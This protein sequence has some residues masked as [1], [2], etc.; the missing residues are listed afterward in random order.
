MTAS[1]GAARATESTGALTGFGLVVMGG[2]VEGAALGLLQAETL[3]DLLGRRRDWVLLTVLLAGLGWAAGSAL[4]TL[5]SG[6]SGPAPALAPILL[7]AAGLGLLMGS[8]LG[9]AQATV[10]RGRVRHPWR[11]VVANGCAWALA[12][13]VVFAGATTAGASWSWLAVA[14]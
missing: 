11:W 5:A 13:P 8:L 12:M 14:A 1:A 2:L 4:A 10:L 7:G 3:R 6:A 9:A